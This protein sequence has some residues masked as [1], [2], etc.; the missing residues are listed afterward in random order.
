[1]NTSHVRPRFFQKYPAGSRRSLLISCNKDDEKLHESKLGPNV[2]SSV[3]GLKEDVKWSSATVIRNDGVNGDGSCRLLHLSVEDQVDVLYGRK[4][5]GVV[6]SV[7]WGDSYTMPGQFVGVRYPAAGNGGTMI[8]ASRLY[9]IA[10]TPYQSRRDS[11]Y[12]G[13]SIIEVVVDKNGPEDDAALAAMG[14]G[15]VIEVSQVIGR[16]FSSL[17]NSYVNLPTALED[18]KNLMLVCVGTRGIVPMRAVLGWTPVLAHA[19]A[20]KITCFYVAPAPAKAAFLT[21]WDSWREAG[22]TFCPI[23]TDSTGDQPDSEGSLDMASADELLT[24]LEW[25]LFMGEHNLSACSAN[26]P[27]NTIV[28][29]AGCSGEVASRLTK[30]FAAKG[31]PGE[32]MLYCDYF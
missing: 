5:K 20:H 21:E 11:A 17:L 12:I 13:A 2:V 18:G 22:V 28:L 32:H 7:K 24:M 15:S 3:R 14:P 9:S 16:G 25:P 27:S 29:L 4:V 6:D 10:S 26:K 19:T 31:V 23:Y 1:M 30:L 8:P